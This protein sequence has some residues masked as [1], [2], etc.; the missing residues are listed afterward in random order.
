MN[1]NFKE[2]AG[3]NIMLSNKEEKNINIMLWWE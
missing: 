3:E 2:T 1:K